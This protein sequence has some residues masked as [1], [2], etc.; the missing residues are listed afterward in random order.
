MRK[1]VS[2]LSCLTP[3]DMTFRRLFRVYVSS[4]YRINNVLQKCHE[5]L[6]SRLGSIVIL[7]MQMQRTMDEAG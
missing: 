5:G 6:N 3:T 1:V 2:P 7:E 4:M